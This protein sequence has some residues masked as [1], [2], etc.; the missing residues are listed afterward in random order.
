MSHAVDIVEPQ[1]PVERLE[2][3]ITDEKESERR[4][5]TKR[6]TLLNRLVRTSVFQFLVGNLHWRKLF[7]KKK[8][9]SGKRYI[10]IEQ[11]FVEKALDVVMFSMLVLAA[12]FSAFNKFLNRTLIKSYWPKFFFGVFCG[13]TVMFVLYEFVT[14]VWARFAQL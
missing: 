6:L 3:D 11:S 4:V 14:L 9:D 10:N 7:S 8:A 13:L 12:P 5:L 1:E 2:N